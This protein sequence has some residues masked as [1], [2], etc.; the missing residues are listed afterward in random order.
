MPAA[1]ER[2]L[3][4]RR[5][6]PRAAHAAGRA[7]ALPALRA[8]RDRRRRATCAA[9]TRLP[10]LATYGQPTEPEPVYAVAFASDDALGRRRRAAVHGAARPLGELPGGRRMS[11]GHGHDHGDGHGTTTAPTVR[12]GASWRCGRARS[13]RCW[14][15]A[16]S[17]STDAIDAIVE[18]LRERRRPAER[19][20]RRRPRVGRRRLPRAPAGRRHGRH[21]ASSATAAPRA[22]TW[23]SSRTR[24]TCTT[25]SSARSARATRGRCWACRRAGTRARRTARARWPSRARCC[26]EFGVELR[27]RRRGAR[28]GL[29]RRGALPRAADAPGG[30]RGLERGGAA[31]ARHARQR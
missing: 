29:E 7:H 27:R 13:R 31:R 16:A 4:A 8:R 22:T 2:A 25:W 5:P 23:S 30:H 18:L 15:S 11:D 1:G 21:R 17:I 26:A 24:R 19:R 9:S 3:R 12:A 20:A 28:L 6:R 14:S 10:D